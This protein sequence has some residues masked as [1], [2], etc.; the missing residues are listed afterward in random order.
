[1]LRLA[2]D[3]E[4]RNGAYLDSLGWVYYRQ[5]KL[6]LA[7][8]FLGQ[9][10]QLMPRDPTVQEHLGDVYAKRGE[11]AKALERYKTAL[12]LEPQPNE[13]AALRS[14]MAETERLTVPRPR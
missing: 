12:D 1:M 3:I 13:E 11:Y 14:K 5:G 6:D 2:V 8:K 9:A 4:P 10:S 7:E